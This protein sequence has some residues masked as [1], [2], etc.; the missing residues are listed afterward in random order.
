MAIMEWRLFF[1]TA[2]RHGEHRRSVSD[3]EMKEML[4]ESM[5]KVTENY[6]GIIDRQPLY[7]QTA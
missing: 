2:R 1:S 7:S 3:S 5:Q 4:G 6:K